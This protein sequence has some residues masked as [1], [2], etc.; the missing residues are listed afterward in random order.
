MDDIK[1]VITHLAKMVLKSAMPAMQHAKTRN[2]SNVRSWPH[3]LDALLARQLHIRHVGVDPVRLAIGPR[4]VNGRQVSKISQLRRT[5]GFLRDEVSQPRVSFVRLPEAIHQFWRKGRRARKD[6]RGI[7]IVFLACVAIDEQQL[8]GLDFVEFLELADV[9]HGIV[10]SGLDVLDAPNSPDWCVGI[11]LQDDVANA[12]AHV[13]EYVGAVKLDVVQHRATPGG[14]MVPYVYATESAFNDMKIS[15]SVPRSEA[16]KSPPRTFTKQAS[17]HN[18][19]PAASTL[20]SKPAAPRPSGRSAT[21]ERLPPAVSELK[22][23]CA[24]GEK[25]VSP[26]TLKKHRPALRLFTSDRRR[27]RGGTMSGNGQ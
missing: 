9:P 26:S 23:C 6:D 15:F 1:L 19:V 25:A 3:H 13:C 4:R 21:A 10:M 11:D 16:S 7:R 2:H 12:R 5:Q 17:S 20:P 22:A 24:H 18:S 8:L 14:A 27:P